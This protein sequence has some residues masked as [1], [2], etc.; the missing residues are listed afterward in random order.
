MA[1]GL[2]A[3]YPRLW[4]FCLVLTTDRTAADDLA[5]STA[6]RAL[7]RAD[8][9]EA[10]TDLDRWLFTMARRIW[11]NDRRSAKVRTGHGVVTSDLTDIPDPAPAVEVNILAREVLDMVQALPDGQRLAVLLVYVEGFS[12]REAADLLDIPIGTVMSR[13]STARKTIATGMA[14]ARI[15]E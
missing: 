11:L 3:L 5:Q 7:S 6:E 10:G 2:P 14:D 13:L 15:H 9:F 8:R 12:Y 4:R 1:D